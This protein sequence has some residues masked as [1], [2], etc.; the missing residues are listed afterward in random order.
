M[1]DQQKNNSFSTDSLK[2]KIAI[3]ENK[4]IE[5]GSVIAKQGSVIAKRDSAINKLTTDLDAAKFQNEQ[6]RWMI[7]G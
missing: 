1:N 2:V 3:L 7:F 4:L 6:L 5:Q